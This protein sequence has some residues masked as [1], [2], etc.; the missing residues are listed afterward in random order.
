VSGNSIWTPDYVP[1]TPILLTKAAEDFPDGGK[2]GFLAWLTDRL[3]ITNTESIE[4]HHGVDAIWRKF[5]N[6]FI[7]LKDIIFYEPI[8]KKVRVASFY[9]E[10]SCC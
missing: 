7:I 6:T 8:F 9:G 4:H 3:T 2:A 10:V 5:Q 1:N